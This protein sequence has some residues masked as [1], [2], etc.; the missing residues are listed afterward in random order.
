MTR[1]V[2]IEEK[3]IRSISPQSGPNCPRCGRAMDYLRTIDG[4][5]VHECPTCFTTPRAA[6][7][8]PLV[9]I[10]VA[11]TLPPSR[12]SMLVG[13]WRITKP[14]YD[15]LGGAAD[16]LRA[17]GRPDLFGLVNEA[18]RHLETVLKRID[19]ATV[20]DVDPRHGGG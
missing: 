3:D 8:L 14:A 15:D 5:T 13:A 17:A 6:T 2:P 19:N 20:A 11:A 4:T 7:G 16:L 9:A 12:A 10:P 1:K 18:R